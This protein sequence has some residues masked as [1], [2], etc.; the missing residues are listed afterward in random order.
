[1]NQSSDLDLE[2]SEAEMHLY[3]RQI[4]LEGWDL[5]AQEKLKLSNVLIVGCG[6][7]GCALAE[8]LARAGVEKLA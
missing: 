2:L 3:S 1:M 8:L 5:E 4:L 6:G 7:I